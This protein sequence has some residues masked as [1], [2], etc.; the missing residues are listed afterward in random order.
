MSKLIF[1]FLTIALS[2]ALKAQNLE[3]GPMLE[4]PYKSFTP[5]IL[6]LR[7]GLLYAADFEKSEHFSEA[8]PD[9]IILQVYN[10]NTL[11]L[12]LNVQIEPREVF[13]RRQSVSLMEVALLGNYFVCF[14]RGFTPTGNL[15]EVYAQRVNSQTGA[16]EVLDTIF[17]KKVQHPGELESEAI[18]YQKLGL[19]NLCMNTTK[20]RIL[21]HH[22]ALSPSS[23][24]YIERVLLLDENLAPLLTR[25]FILRNPEDGMA[26]N[27]LVDSQ[28]SVYSYSNRKMV[29]LDFT[30]G[31]Q[32]LEQPIP[33][34]LIPAN[35]FVRQLCATIHDNGNIAWAG[36]YGTVD[37]EDTE[38]NKDASETR[39]GD[40]QIE[41]VVYL[42]VDAATKQLKRTRRS[43]FSEDLINEFLNEELMKYHLDTEI[44][45]VFTSFEFFRVQD[46]SCLIGEAADYNNPAGV[47]YNDLLLTTF[48]EMGEVLWV[49]R[50]PKLQS[51][52][53]VNRATGYL[54]FSDDET[55]YILFQD[56][57]EN[58]EEGVRK[59]YD[60]R[61]ANHHKYLIPVLYS[62]N[63]ETGNF[64]YEPKLNWKF[65][66]DLKILPAQAYQSEE[67]EPVYVFL[68]GD[69][70]YRLSRFSLY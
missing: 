23:E 28:G 62:F 43:K 30:R 27:K 8:L 35:A 70:N 64:L 53:P 3:M 7:N 25:D 56:D 9:E 24:D 61:K 5:Q 34:K 65:G 46:F 36:L 22:I 44:N 41:G 20:S 59:V 16:V 15:V 66:K 18:I 1:I 67:G 2:Y 14:Y 68:R 40:T 58:F 49:H 21:I 63:K 45:D 29:M 57:L 6:E 42:E 37:L 38:E 26:M 11:D 12:K 19:L 31:Y 32:R 17:S 48:D 10:Q 52:G 47:N 55:L 4:T 54:S 39:R 50:L 33:D 60:L 51:Y 13:E 69:E